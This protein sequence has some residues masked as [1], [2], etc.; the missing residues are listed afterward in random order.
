MANSD[1]LSRRNLLSVMPMASVLRA[2]PRRPN[3]VLILADDLGYGDLA[4]YGNRYNA[5]PNLDALARSGVR[6][7][8]FHSNGAVCSP[9]RAALMTGRYQQRCGIT[10]VIAAA[11]PRDHGLDPAETSFAAQLKKAGYRTA[12]YGKWHLGYQPR[13]NPDKHGFDDFR[14]YVSGNVDYVSHIDQAGRADWWHN[15]RLEPETGYVTDLINAHAVR[16]IEANRAGPFL[17]YI[18]HEAVHYP[19]QKRGDGPLRQAGQDNAAN[20]RQGVQPVYREMLRAMDEGVGQVVRTLQRLGL[21]RDTLIFFFSDN[22]AAAAGSNGPWRGAK[23]SVWEGGH[24]VPAIASWPGRIPAGRTSD[25][26]AM[27]MDLYATLLEASGAPAPARPL[28][29]V[30]LL[31][32]LEKGSALPGRTLFWGHAAQRAARQGDWKLTAMPGQRPFLSNLRQ[33]PGERDD[34]SENQPAQ[35]QALL[36]ALATWEKETNPASVPGAMR[37]NQ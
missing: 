4:C 32:H 2:P 33:D 3:I 15:S 8:D 36:D 13:F 25:A 7:A 23:G 19:Y 20:S 1:N 24:R 11:G 9:T 37:R 6:F 29:G 35:A 16:F 10:E 17:L 28:D 27:S 21:E 12:I 31:T 14:G 34:L 5:T 22:G 26:T 30:S 18:A